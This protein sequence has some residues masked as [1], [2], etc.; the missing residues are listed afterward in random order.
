M[1]LGYGKKPLFTIITHTYYYN[2]YVQLDFKT[3]V[4]L[5]L[6][7][8]APWWPL[9]MR[10]HTHTHSNAHTSRQPY[11]QEAMKSKADWLRGSSAG[12][13]VWG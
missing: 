13:P 2:T 5:G 9:H 4:N 12:S 6:M 11:P 10:E 7:P 3:G 8:I 1:K